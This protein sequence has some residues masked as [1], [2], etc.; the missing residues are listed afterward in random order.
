MS[1]ESDET[2]SAGDSVNHGEGDQ[3]Y[4]PEREDEAEYESA[5]ERSR[6]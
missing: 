2:A 4:D 1:Q 6:E 5:R 3:E